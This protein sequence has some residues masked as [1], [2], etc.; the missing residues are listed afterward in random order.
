MKK[1][2]SLNDWLSY[3]ESQHPT[4][5]D[6]SLQ[7]C[8]T[9]WQRMRFS[10]AQTTIITVAGTNGKGSCCACLQHLIHHAG[11]TTGTYASPHVE[12]F[13]ER[14]QLGLNECDDQQICQAFERIEQH[15][16]EISLTYFEYATLAALIIFA[17]A[18][19]DVVILEVGLG[20]RLDATNIVDADVAVITSIGFDHQDWLGDTLADIAM[21]KSGIIKPSSQIVVGY[22]ADAL[23]IPSLQCG[24]NALVEVSKLVH[25]DS[26]HNKIRL[27]SAFIADCKLFGEPDSAIGLRLNI[28][29]D[30][31]A[32]QNI[33]TSL[34]TL[35]RIMRIKIEYRERIYSYF[36]DLNKLQS[37]LAKVLLPGRYQVLCDTPKM[38]ADVAHNAQATALLAKRLK[39]EKYARV[40]FVV[41]ML[42]DKNIAASMRELLSFSATWL[43]CDL[44]SPR[45]EKA[46]QLERILNNMQIQPLTFQSVEAA[47]N[48]ALEQAH[49]TDI[50]CVFGS[51]V[52]VAE[53]SRTIKLRQKHL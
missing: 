15:R 13:N 51:F 47:V 27:N 34:V 11:L 22:D 41:G 33:A 48:S 45:G 5:I 40:F 49:N 2:K 53:A 25:V 20:G 1:T 10:F 16:A 19:L 18:N 37:V 44:P 21:E 50:I 8:I 9:V 39:C 29:N 14:I 12:R 24:A 36:T 46:E 6:M 23:G 52:T 30:R 17:Q 26:K 3:I 38:M 4:A 28:Q 43:C 42:R 35:L 7:R 31:L 32:A